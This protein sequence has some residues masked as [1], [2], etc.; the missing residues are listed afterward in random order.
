[1]NDCVHE[2]AFLFSVYRCMCAC[3]ID[4]YIYI[5]VCAYY[6]IYVCERTDS[7]GTSYCTWIS[8]EVRVA[9]LL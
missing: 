3:R 1:M 4:I 8:L 9:F 7:F 2:K 6:C 5:Y